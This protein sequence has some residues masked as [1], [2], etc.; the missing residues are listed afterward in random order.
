MTNLEAFVSRLRTPTATVYLITRGEIEIV[1]R[2]EYLRRDMVAAE[3]DGAE[4][5]YTTE[6]AFIC[7]LRQRGM[8]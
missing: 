6:G 2:D 3:R 7:A 4:V 5:R 8:S 1:T